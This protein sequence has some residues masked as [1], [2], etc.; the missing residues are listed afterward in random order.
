[1]AVQRQNYLTPNEYLEIERKAKYKSEYFGGEMFAMAGASARHIRIVHNLVRCIDDQLLDRP[2]ETFS[3]EMRV[4]VSPAGLYTYPDFAALCEP[5]IFSDSHQDMILNP[6]VL[7]E[8]LSASTADYDRTEKFEH[9][10]RI[11]SFREYLLIAQDRVYVEHYVKQP[12]TTWPLYKTYGEGDII[13][14]AAINCNMPMADIYRKVNPGPEW[15]L[16]G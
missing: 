7:M 15:E 4:R 5:P 1:M 9:Y 13:W 12:D 3:Y 2:C 10:K 14:I 16:R 8:V 11:A 6:S